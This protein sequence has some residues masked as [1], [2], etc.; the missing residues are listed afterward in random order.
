MLKAWF[1]QPIK[2]DK[3]CAKQKAIQSRNQCCD[4]GWKKICGIPEKDETAPDWGISQ[5]KL[6]LG[7]DTGREI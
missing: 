2:G 3:M 1:Q 4:R 5:G 7:G 6:P